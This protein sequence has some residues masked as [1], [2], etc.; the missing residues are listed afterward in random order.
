MSC[1]APALETN[2]YCW[3]QR[4]PKLHTFRKRGVIYLFQKLLKENRASPANISF[5]G[6]IRTLG[7]R[8]SESLK[9]RAVLIPSGTPA[10]QFTAPTPSPP[11]GGVINRITQRPGGPK[12]GKTNIPFTGCS[13]AKAV[14]WLISLCSSE[15]Q[16]RKELDRNVWWSGGSREAAYIPPAGSGRDWWISW[17]TTLWSLTCSVLPVPQ[18][19]WLPLG[20]STPAVGGQ[21][22]GLEKVQLKAEPLSQGAEMWDTEQQ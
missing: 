6:Y 8:Q 17:D 15:P 11:T 20:E 12:E 7:S 16:R 19:R 5:L 22:E 9:G 1:V 18:P 13:S 10:S 14:G 21:Q 4:T 3:G 2:V